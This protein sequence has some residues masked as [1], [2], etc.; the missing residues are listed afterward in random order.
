[1]KMTV[2][3]HNSHFHFGAFSDW[4]TQ[5]SDNIEFH[6]EF[7]FSK[8]KTIVITEIKTAEYLKIKFKYFNKIRLKESLKLRQNHFERHL[9]L[10]QQ[11]Y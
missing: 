6:V 11:F 9:N 1:M 8:Q 7:I 4:I 10:L 3:I 5:K 2:M